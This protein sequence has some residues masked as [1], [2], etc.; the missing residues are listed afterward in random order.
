MIF[1]VNDYI[2]N[3]TFL[4]REDLIFRCC[5]PFSCANT[6][7]IWLFSVTTDHCNVNNE[8]NTS[9]KYLKWF[10]YSPL[11]AM[12]GCQHN[13]FVNQGTSTFVDLLYGFVWTY[14]LFFENRYHPWEFAELSFVLRTPFDPET[15]TFWV[16]MSTPFSDSGTWCNPFFTLQCIWRFAADM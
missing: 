8:D 13:L 12:S 10:N 9:R 2:L 14:R 4:V 3:G 6:Q 11:H 5:I 1:L 15:Y 16:S 7:L